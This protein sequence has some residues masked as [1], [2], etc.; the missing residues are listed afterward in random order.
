MSST[1]PAPDSL[2]RA[3]LSLLI[4]RFGDRTCAP[5][6]RWERQRQTTWWISLE[7]GESAVWKIRHVHKLMCRQ[8]AAAT[9]TLPR[10]PVDCT[11]GELEHFLVGALQRCSSSL[12]ADPVLVCIPWGCWRDTH[13]DA[14][15]PA[16]IRGHMGSLERAT[17]DCTTRWGRVYTRGMRVDVQRLLEWD[18][19]PA[20][21]QLA[22][23]E[24]HR[25]RWP[26]RCHKPNYRSCEDNI[27]HA[28]PEFDRLFDIGLHRQVGAFQS[29]QRTAC[30]LGSTSAWCESRAS[31]TWWTRLS[32]SS[33]ATWASASWT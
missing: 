9:G 22:L 11:W 26:G 21:L 12:Q 25:Y 17:A 19:L 30:G 15:G 7:S 23:V 27:E 31:S 10:V 18:F 24:G 6:P 29:A 4:D 5:A 32:L 33:C 3:V 20:D 13:A 2:Q 28:A 14:S 16:A 1:Q 8:V